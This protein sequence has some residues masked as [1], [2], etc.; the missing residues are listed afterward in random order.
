MGKG[1]ADAAVVVG[2][3]N[4]L[5]SNLTDEKVTQVTHAVFKSLKL[6]KSLTSIESLETLVN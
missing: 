3:S 1:E 4:I 2:L 5:F 6:L